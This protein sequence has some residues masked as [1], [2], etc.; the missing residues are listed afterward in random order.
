MVWLHSGGVPQG[1]TP[2]NPAA[3][4]PALLNPALHPQD[5]PGREM[6]AALVGEDT[7]MSVPKPELTQPSWA[8]LQDQSSASEL[9]PPCRIPKLCL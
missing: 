2:T 6:G 9:C 7:L 4:A 5:S 3:A 1:L 8:A